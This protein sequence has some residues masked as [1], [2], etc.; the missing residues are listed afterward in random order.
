MKTSKYL[1]NWVNSRRYLLAPRTLDC[2]EATIRIHVLPKLGDKKLRKLKPE[3]LFDLLDS[4]TKQG[5]SRTAELTYTILKKALKDAVQSGIIDQSP[6]D[7]VARPHHKSVSYAHLD[8]TEIHAYLSAALADKHAIAWCLGLFC[9]LRRGEICGLRWE[10][11]DLERNLL[12]V[13]NQRQR[14]ASGLVVDRQPKSGA[15]DRIIPLS[16]ELIGLLLLSWQSSGYVVQS[17]RGVPIT[18][19]SLDRCHKKMLTN[20]GLNPV[21]IHGLRHTMGSQ[22]IT[23]GVH[24]KILQT[25]LGHSSYVTTARYY[26]DVTTPAMVSAID[27]IT[28]SMV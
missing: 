14:L 9:G 28:A 22:A 17:C 2:Y 20:A 12:H 8:P 3:H 15:G 6:M 19:A 27:R 18:P 16:P 7:L 21:T 10:D 13:R 1:S 24:I 23:S 5:K 25:L 4:L 11:I 26:A